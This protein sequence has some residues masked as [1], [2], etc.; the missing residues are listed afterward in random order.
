MTD[1]RDAEDTTPTLDGGVPVPIPESHPTPRVVAWAARSQVGSR[2]RENQDRWDHRGQQ[3]FLLADGMGGHADGGVAA[4]AACAVLRDA[5]VGSWRDRV[6]V[7]NGAVRARA[8]AG[9]GTT[10][11]V[12]EVVGGRA[13]VVSVGDSRLYRVR[14][15]R[16]EQLTEDHTLRG[17]LLTAGID[18]DR[19]APER[20]TRGLTSYLGI[21]PRRLR[22]D[23]VDVPV[24]AGDRFLLCSDGI[25]DAVAPAALVDA[26]H[27][28]DC[29]GG[30]EE[31]L[32]A[33]TAAGGGDDATAIVVDVA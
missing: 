23:V 32:A 8:A 20:Q 12:L 10:V 19:H 6:V 33:R 30:V 16:L 28:G 7:A 3:R 22:V 17:E 14:A 4:A 25:H 5:G 26:L 9:A 21:D 31:L 1:L 15:G 29:A 18:A 2:R 27:T 11:L 24:A 13:T